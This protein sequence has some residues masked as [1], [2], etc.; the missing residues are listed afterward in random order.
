MKP[1]DI[2]RRAPNLPTLSPSITRLLADLAKPNIDND[3][4]VSC[5]RQDVV[6]SAKVLSLCNSAAFGFS[7]PIDSIE[8]AT[9]LLGQL[10]LR[11]LVLALAFGDALGASLPGYDIAEGSL[12]RHSLLT[13]LIAEHIAKTNSVVLFDPSVAYTAALIHDIGKLAIGQAIDP[14]TKDKILSLVENQNR[15]LIDAERECLGTDHA[16]VGGCLLTLW[17]LPESLVEAVA[18]HHSPTPS[19]PPSLSSLV[20][21]SNLIAHEVGESPGMLSFAQHCDESAVARLGLNHND[22]ESLILT[23]LDFRSDVDNTSEKE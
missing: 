8:Y 9:V 7:S 12:W 15:S 6:L 4:I 22:I 14:K 19:N 13:A 5:I 23:A 17:R 18:C 2:I 3:R 10:E 21:V 11:R 1:Q 20:H 16:E